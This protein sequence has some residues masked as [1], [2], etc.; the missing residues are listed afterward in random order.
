[1]VGS[2]E[3]NAEDVIETGFCCM[4]CFYHYAPSEADLETHHLR[5]HHT[6]GLPCKWPGCY[7]IMPDQEA[8]NNHHSHIHELRTYVCPS[9]RCHLRFITHNETQLHIDQH[10]PN[11]EDIVL[12][13]LESRFRNLDL[14]EL[15]QEQH[16][17]K[18]WW[19]EKCGSIE[20]Q[21]R[22]VAQLYEMYYSPTAR[23]YFGAKG[24]LEQTSHPNTTNCRSIRG[25]MKKTASESLRPKGHYGVNGR[26]GLVK[27]W[28]C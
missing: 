28:D 10:H 8:L 2:G 6:D 3:N 14:G 27:G 20:E 25:L 12:S 13:F 26:K 5:A 21:Q 1:M 24:V 22:K 18:Q 11:G 19:D 15:R 4:I 9:Q 23:A 17:A 7:A 16:V